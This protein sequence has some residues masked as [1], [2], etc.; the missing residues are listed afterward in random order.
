MVSDSKNSAV[1]S[2][3]PKNTAELVLEG[4][5]TEFAGLTTMLG[6]KMSDNCACKAM[7]FKMNDIYAKEGAAAYREQ[8]EKIISFIQEN[9]NKWG[10]SATTKAWASAG[11]NYMLHPELWKRVK[12]TDPIPGLFWYSLELYESKPR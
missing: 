8:A 6:I 7:M 11:W 1:A 3:I 10:W 2:E 9:M 12:P 4:P 5:G